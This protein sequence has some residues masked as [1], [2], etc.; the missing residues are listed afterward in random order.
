MP[1]Y[2]VWRPSD[3]SERVVVCYEMTGGSTI[4]TQPFTSMYL[5]LTVISWLFLIQYNFGMSIFLIPYNPGMSMFLIQYN[6]GMS[7]FFMVAI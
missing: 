3:E 1:Y 2:G 4:A 7:I 6:S 5:F